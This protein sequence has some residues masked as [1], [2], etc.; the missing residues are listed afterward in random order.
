MVLQG[1][2]DNACVGT[3]P[4]EIA[5]RAIELFNRDASEGPVGLSQE[6]R[7]LFADEPVIVPFRAALEDT[8][9]SGPDAL[10]RFYAA[11]TESWEWLRIDAETFEEIGETACVVSGTLTGR[12]RATGAETRADV[13]WALEVADGRIAAIRTL[14][15]RREALEAASG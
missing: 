13:W 1:S 2:S 3:T 11:S 9:Y 14:P 10:D 7:A 5:R 6:T 12:G 8:V 4:S 15:S